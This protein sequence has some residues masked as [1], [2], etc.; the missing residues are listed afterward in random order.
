MLSVNPV[1]P[2]DSSISGAVYADVNDSG[3]R[4]P[5]ELGVPGV[6]LTL[7]GVD[8]QGTAVEAAMLTDADG[9]YSFGDLRPGTYEIA[10][11]QPTAM[12]DGRDSIGSLGGIVG[13]D[14]LSGIVLTGDSHSIDNNFGER[15]L[16][17]QY[18]SIGYFFSTAPPPEEYL[19]EK[20]CYAEEMAGN[21][22]LAAAIRA[23]ITK[24]PW[25]PWGD[26]PVADNDNYSVAEDGTL[27]KNA[28]DGVLD[29]DS[30]VDGDT[31]TAD[32]VADVSHGTLLLN[33][34]GSFSYTPDADFH[35]T[36]SFTYTA[37]D[38]I[39]DSNVATVA[40][41]VTSVD[42]L[43]VADPQ[44]VSTPEDTAVEITLTGD[45]GDPE[46]VQTLTF[47]L[48]TPPAHGTLSGFDPQT[49][50]VT[51]TP[52]AD[53]FGADSFTFTVN[54]GEADSA[55]VTVA[56]DVTEVNNLPVADPQT[57]STPEDTGAEITLAGDDGDP[58]KTQTLTFAL[59]TL[60]VH[61]TLTGFNPQTGAVTY[62]PSANYHGADSFT[63]AV[64]DGGADSA[65][66]TVSID[67]TAVNDLPVADPQDVST[68]ED[69]PVQITLTGD[70][71]DP[72]TTQT[73]TFA[74]GSLPIHG[75]LSG[76][77]PQ[78][79][80]VTYT[81]SAN[82]HGADSFTFIVND[83]G[84]D[85]AE[86]TVAVDVTAVNDLPT[87]NFQ[88]VSTPEDTAAAITLTGDDGDPET[89]QTL[90]FALGTLPIHGT[91]SGFNPQTGSVTYTP[92]ANYHGADSFTFTVND[93]EADS[94]EATVA[95]GVTAVDDPPVAVDDDAT[96]EEGIPVI[97]DVLD[98]DSDADVGDVPVVES[99]TQAAHGTVAINVDGTL[100]YTPEPGFNG[101]DSFTYTLVGGQG[102]TGTATVDVT[103]TPAPDLPLIIVGDHTLLPDT[104]DQQI[105]VL[106]FGDQ[107]VEG[108]NFWVQIADGGPEAA[109]GGFI[110]PPGIDG[111][112]IT[113]VDLESGIFA[114][115]NTGQVNHDTN[116]TFPQLY[117]AFIVTAAGTVPADGLFATVTIDTTGFDSGSWT[118]SLSNTLA[119][120]TAI[121]F[122]GERIL[123]GSI[124]IA[125]DAAL[126]VEEDWLDGV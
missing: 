31:L 4:D 3:Q 18:I 38:G 83:G 110:D 21:F 65:E 34:N 17:P 124:T 123:D 94:A 108:I 55:E 8:D 61:G 92:S 73:L 2:A 79:G 107:P 52:S 40:I 98:N 121:P 106:I 23:S 105:Y 96:T 43:P 115:N 122:V 119:G 76:F 54:D 75:T 91:L 66:A 87:A 20:M 15:G 72:E 13:D 45:D 14:R 118:L 25:D 36:D 78:T 100:T 58:D 9:L 77:N 64:N 56:I 50:A 24:W 48:G 26:P 42:D 125:V 19:L 12:L 22:N 70:D 71:G 102:S 32:L 104:A 47:A 116:E 126:A 82:Y 97:I 95:I 63:F 88:T 80:T 39:H 117:G 37:S 103:V 51:Y 81:P 44:D 113:S 59:G 68:A 1:L 53:Y 49:G 85:S 89:A 11:T 101:N 41:T 30:D 111:P 84:A 46:T 112:H 114:P 99:V 120:S 90:T 29:N 27:V 6:I 60:P 62:T 33:G 10:E 16:L 7:S 35:G 57:V 5:E 86:A 28:G 93:G 67:V 74:L 109:A 69:T